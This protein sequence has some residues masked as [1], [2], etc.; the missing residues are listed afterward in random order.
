MIGE[1]YRDIPV[2]DIYPK[3]T[4]LPD[5]ESIQDLVDYDVETSGLHPD[6]GSRVSVVSLAWM[7][8]GEIHA[9]CWPFGQGDHPKDPEG[10]PQADL[11]LVQW[12]HLLNWLARAGRGLSGHN[13]AFDLMQLDAGTINGYPGRRLTH[14]LVWD[15]Y[16]AAADIWPRRLH[17]LKPLSVWLF[18]TDADAEQQALKPWL[19]PKTDPRYHLVP[20]RVM[21]PY[22]L[23]DAVL[24]TKL[25]HLEADWIAQGEEGTRHLGR[26][27]EILKALVRLQFAGV[28]YD[29][30]LSLEQDRLLEG[31]ME[32]LAAKL[33]FLPKDA[34]QYWFGRPYEPHNETGR[35]RPYAWTDGG[36][37]GVPKPSLT[38]DIL[39]RMAA[40]GIEFADVMLEYNRYKS[41]RS[42]WYGPFA[43]LAGPD[44]RLRTQFKQLG[45]RSGRF[46]A[47]RVNLQAVPKD[48][49]L[50]LPV[51]TPRQ[52]ITRAT[53]DRYP[54]WELWD[55]DLAQAEL[56]VAALYANC[57]KMLDAVREG[58]DLHTE[59][60][61]ELFQIEPDHPD[62]AFNRQ[63]AKR[64]NFSLIFGSGADT[65][66]KMVLKESGVM[67]SLARAEDIV[68]S[69]RDLY[70]EYGYKIDV[71][72]ELCK[73]RGYVDLPSGRKRWYAYGED[74]HSAFNQLVQA[75]LAQFSN[76]W[77]VH[78][79][80]ELR[81]YRT[82]LRDEFPDDPGA[83]G[84]LLVV[85]D[86]QLMLLPKD[87]AKSVTQEVADAA[88]N[89]WDVWFPGVPGGVDATQWTDA[90]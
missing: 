2:H 43:K 78:T 88:V 1:R 20:W 49:K 70:P 29:S 31:H 72:M 10:E 41:A 39:E 42:K 85:H 17:G 74:A 67:L 82:R 12:R 57:T 55:L 8:D 69:W 16:L 25:R 18:E 87:E 48:F 36:K 19:G 71:E 26:N 75:Q 58:R 65:F 3:P 24:T 13:I 89:L 50:H 40:E 44:D 14:R 15:T 45:T 34:N 51:L 63:I 23:S 11:G 46:S 27:L 21:R 7:Q 90:G 53:R 81:P 52:I 83:G 5:P 28:P 47:T 9:G 73:D 54:G 61:A 84:L 68:Y 86:S 66:R 59:T 4:D 38:G 30:K 37:S 76:A 79:D 77:F 80:R 60:T 32:Q 64:A 6:S 62:F 22:A 33:P 35:L 56:R